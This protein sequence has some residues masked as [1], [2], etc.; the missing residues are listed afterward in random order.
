MQTIKSES[1]GEVGAGQVSVFLKS[2][3]G[4]TLLSQVERHCSG[5]IKDT[6]L[7]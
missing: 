6:A 3:T 1:R 5:L 4:M 2:S 7:E